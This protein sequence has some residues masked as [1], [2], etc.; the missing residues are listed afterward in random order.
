[1]PADV[2][3]SQQGE[4]GPVKSDGEIRSHSAPSCSQTER[5]GEDAGFGLGL[6]ST[7][8][9]RQPV[10]LAAF[11]PLQRPRTADGSIIK[12]ALNETDE[13]TMTQQ[14][15]VLQGMI[16]G[17]LKKKIDVTGKQVTALDTAV[18]DVQN[19]VDNITKTLDQ[20]NTGFMD[21]LQ[22]LST[23]VN[24]QKQHVEARLAELQTRLD[25]QAERNSA[26]QESIEKLGQSSSTSSSSKAQ[27]SFAAS[28]KE[29]LTKLEADF[30]AS[31]AVVQSLVLRVENS[32]QNLTATI[33]NVVQSALEEKLKPLAIQLD[34][35]AMES[36]LTNQIES[37]VNAMAE[38]RM[39]VQSLRA[40]VEETSAQSARPTSA[41]TRQHVDRTP[42]PR[43]PV[44][45]DDLTLSQHRPPVL[46]D[47]VFMASTDDMT[48]SQAYSVDVLGLQSQLDVVM[49]AMVE[50]ADADDV[51]ELG[52][53][54]SGM[55]SRL[56]DQEQELSTKLDMKQVQ[57]VSEGIDDRLA[58]FVKRMDEVHDDVQRRASPEDLARLKEA[59]DRCKKEISIVQNTLKD[60]MSHKQLQ[61][62]VDAV[63]VMRTEMSGVQS[64][65]SQKADKNEFL[66]RD[67]TVRALKLQLAGGTFERSSRRGS[68][69]STG[70]LG[71]SP[72]AP[73]IS[74]SSKAKLTAVSGLK[75]SP[76]KR[77]S[78][79]TQSSDKESDKKAKSIK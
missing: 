21:D 66:A 44:L 31:N 51:A 29:R 22:T 40:T 14:Q 6:G 73:K 49:R 39:Q 43:P 63:K 32:E 15:G 70:S 2:S 45:A 75:S 30:K 55:Q 23:S 64:S 34:I 77:S 41:A 58:G 48:G 19:S 36:K 25:Q 57:E 53:L 47:D 9:R 54:V 67:E 12:S 33:T 20:Q 69:S 4:P 3:S 8:P 13:A 52:V 61:P 78:T 16:A 35:N 24:D 7:L 5:G 28:V 10:S 59:S 62:L 37:S 17:S 27:E 60:K 11:S 38:V 76:E 74:G 50:K 68:A 26:T 65:V 1:M 72:E 56:D 42:S 71:I 79:P 18:V 46:A